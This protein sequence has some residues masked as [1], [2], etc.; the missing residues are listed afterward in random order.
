M[1]NAELSTV[2]VPVKSVPSCDARSVYP[3]ATT[4]M[5]IASVAVHVATPLV[6]MSVFV[7]FNVALPGLVWIANVMLRLSFVTVLFAWS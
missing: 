2:C 6:V 5:F 7:P 1:L 4:V 3:V